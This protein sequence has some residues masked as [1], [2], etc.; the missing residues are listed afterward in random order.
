MIPSK[1]L[2]SIPF[3]LFWNIPFELFK[4]ILSKL[5]KNIPSAFNLEYFFQIL[6]KI[7]LMY[8]KVAKIW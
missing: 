8:E 3:E 6:F 1:L 5:V 4:N 7:E 2:C